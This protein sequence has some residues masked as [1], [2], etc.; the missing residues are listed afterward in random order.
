M[1]LEKQKKKSTSVENCSQHRAYV[2]IG[3]RMATK[4][5]VNQRTWKWTI[6]LLFFPPSPTYQMLTVVNSYILNN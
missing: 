2:D 4:H 3:V 6:E 1:I 5:S